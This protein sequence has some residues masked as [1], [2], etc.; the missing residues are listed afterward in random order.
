MKAL[1]TFLFTS[2]L[3]SLS[4]QAQQTISGQ[5]RDRQGNALPGAN[6]FIKDSYDG[7]TS[8]LK[9]R[10]SF[11]T[12][13]QGSQVMVISYISYETQEKVLALSGKSVEVR[14]VL[15]EA[16]NKLEGVTI[17]AGSFGAGDEKKATSL[18]PLDIL[19]TAGAVGD[20]AGALQTMPG[21]QTVAEDGRLFVR[22][23]SGEE[24]QVFIDGLYVQNPY[25]ASIQQVPTRGRFSPF[26]FKG[27]LFSTGGYSAEY[28]QAMS[29]V[30]NLQ[31]KDVAAESKTDISLM[32]VGVEVEHTLAGENQSFA[33]KVGYMNLAPY[34]GLVEQGIDWEQEP[35]SGELS[36]AYRRKDKNEGLLKIYGNQQFQQMALSQPDLLENKENTRYG[37]ESRNSF[38]QLHYKKPVGKKTVWEGGAAYTFDRQQLQMNDNGRATEQGSLHLKSKWIIDFASRLSINSGLVLFRQSFANTYTMRAGEAAGGSFTDY[39]GAAFVEADIYLSNRLVAR[40]GGR[41]DYSAYLQKAA[42]APRLSVAY[43]TSKASQ[44][45]FAYGSFY[46]KPQANFL[47]ASEMLDNEKS[48]HYILNYQYEKEGQFLRLEGYYKGY[49]K[50]IRFE[51]EGQQFS[52]TRLNN[53]GDGYARGIELFYRNKSLIKN[54]DFWLSY[55]FLDSE[56]L[57]RNYPE[58]AVPSF[59]SRHNLSLVYKHFIADW[60]SMVGAS[61][62][63]ASGRPFHNPNKAGFQQ[64]KTSGYQNLSLNWAYLHRQHIIFYTSL[65]N[66]LG[67]AN[68]GGYR[69]ASERNEAGIFE[70]VPVRPGAKRFFFVGA[71]IT[72]TK[73]GNANQLDRL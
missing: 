10:F 42:L 64:E 8:D 12:E 48:T 69:F 53:D 25:N 39:L 63:L 51:E 49:R 46:Q 9:G 5:V 62:S 14:V 35:E 72:L 26:M 24:S 52:Y 1:F 33:G 55:S 20:I 30:L 21:T 22:G 34:M 58:K 70:S 15:K 71:F 61:W 40:A 17:T 28:G 11:S 19:T 37:L 66:V 18:T 36:L 6:I 45:S 73:K 16:I 60:K 3:L 27:T 32:S 59:A 4:L 43:Q 67:A 31:T 56:R 54:V 13:E 29:S 47:L 41:F 38:L 57:Y 65:S 2:L 68:T 23:G 44:L 7:A 50:L